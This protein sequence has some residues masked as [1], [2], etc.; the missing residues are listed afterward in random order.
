MALAITLHDPKPGEAWE[1][2]RAA[3][4]SR[5]ASWLKWVIAIDD[6]IDGEDLD[7][8]LWALSWRVQPYCDVQIQ[9]GRNT[10]LD[11]SG[12]PVEDNFAARIYPDGLGGSQILIDTTR[13]W[14]YPPVSLPSKDLME[15]ARKIWEELKLPELTPAF[16][17][18]GMSSATG[19]TAGTRQRSTPCAASTSRPAKTSATTARYPPTL[20]PARSFR[21]RRSHMSRPRLVIGVSGAS[22]PQLAWAV[23]ER[24]TPARPSRPTW[25]SRRGRRRRSPPRWG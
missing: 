5:N 4:T 20:I 17:G 3:A 8:V 6:D 24:F 16:R 23:L 15:D 21:Q 7:S 9:R 25:R 2:V 14:A 10:D 11:P 13:A 18:T 19:P 12:A 22:A 1:A